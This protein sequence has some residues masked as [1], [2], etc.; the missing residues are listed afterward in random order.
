M[1]KRP[2]VVHVLLR[3]ETWGLLLSGRS[4]VVICILPQN[5]LPVSSVAVLCSVSW[6]LSLHVAHTCSLWHKNVAAAHFSS[7]ARN[8]QSR[9]KMNLPKVVLH[10]VNSSFELNFKIRKQNEPWRGA[11]LSALSASA[12]SS[13]ASCAR[14]RWWQWFLPR[15]FIFISPELLNIDLIFF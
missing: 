1:W 5:R 11:P 13:P 8:L 14:S 10:C 7:V 3:L 9:C 15:G 6:S 12:P 2:P 4:A